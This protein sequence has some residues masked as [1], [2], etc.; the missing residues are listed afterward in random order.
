[1]VSVVQQQ[2]TGGNM[3]NFKVT[4]EITNM[5]GV[6]SKREIQIKAKTEKSAEKK[7]WEIIG[8]QSGH[9]VSVIAE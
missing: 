4:I 6:S 3:K 9:V 8:N 2:T 7:A 5:F 1:M